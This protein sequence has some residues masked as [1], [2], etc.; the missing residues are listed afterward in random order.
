MAES[1]ESV[2]QSIMRI[3]DERLDPKKIKTAVVRD[4]YV[5]VLGALIGEIET[6]M[7]AAKELSF[8]GN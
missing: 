3:V 8:D 5:S 1:V 7:N 4:R 2:A 6:S